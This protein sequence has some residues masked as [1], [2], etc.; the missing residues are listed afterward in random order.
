MLNFFG[1]LAP[2]VMGASFVVSLGAAGY[3]K[4]KK[5]ARMCWLMVGSAAVNYALFLVALA[6]R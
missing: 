2:L 4:S 5:R 3:Y 6:G 1:N